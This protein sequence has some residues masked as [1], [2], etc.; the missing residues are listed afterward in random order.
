MAV[1]NWVYE[2]VFYQIFPDRFANGDPGNDP[3]NVV[4]WGTRPDVTHFMGGDLEG[5]RQKLD[6]LSDL[7]INALYLNPIFISPSTH[8]YNI[9]DYFQIDPKLGNLEDFK[10]LLKEAHGRGMRV[11][12]DGVFNHCGRGFFAFNDI[13][14]N[15]KDSP[16]L[17]WYY[18][19]KLP[20]NAYSYGPARNYEAW[21]N[22]KP[23]PKFNT[24]TAGVRK[25]L[26]DVSRYWIEL[27]ADGWRLDVPNE[28]ND[29]S[30]W[31]EF[32]Q[33]VYKANPEAY[34]IGEIWNVDPRWVS[35]GHFDGLMH[36]PQR[37]A[38][39][40][41]LGGDPDADFPEFARRIDY[42]AEVYPQDN[43]FAMYNLLGSHDTERI[44]TLQGGNVARTSL[45]FALQFA[46]PGIPAIYYGDEVGMEGGKD[47]DCRGAFPWE[48]SRWDSAFREKVKKLV[49]LRKE[50]KSFQVGQCNFLNNGDNR[51]HL[52]FLRQ[53]EGE[54]VLVV[55][56]PGEADTEISLPLDGLGLADGWKGTDLLDG[57]TAAQVQDGHLTTRLAG[58]GSA[59]F[60]L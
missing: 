34:T 9:T 51:T 26:L 36:Y 22:F 52:A 27:G 57:Q 55:A 29:D 21:W 42:F 31:A 50:L 5:I 53:A 59:Y 25:Y 11:I 17:D 28:I 4:P 13:L 2:S 60:R 1:P 10:H 40:D 32:R 23:M 6:Y 54:R 14:E 44:K 18:V 43:L 41:L 33:V 24:N 8:R 30:F 19:H 45:A 58:W 7:G 46:L 47:P 12:L 16:Y 20:L 49:A 35:E 37:G 56:N 15:G 38:I 48:E 39:L 3:T